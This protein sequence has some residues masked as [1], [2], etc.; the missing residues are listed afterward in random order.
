[1]INGVRHTGIVVNDIEGAINFWVGILDLKIVSNQVET[2]E[3]INRLLALDSVEVQTVKLVA[4]DNSMIELLHFKSH[5]HKEYWEGTPYSTG[6][7]HIALNVSNIGVVAERL[8]RLGYRVLAEP[9]ISSDGKVKVSYVQ[10]F[11]GL[12]LELVES[13]LIQNLD[14]N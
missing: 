13:Q 10:A 9:Q 11:E 7:T 6:L 12:L 5:S 2:G 8:T 1:M 3:F 14:G 4:K